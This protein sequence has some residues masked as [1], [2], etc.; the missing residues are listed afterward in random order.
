MD[1]ER[2]PDQ[3]RN[4]E[5]ARQIIADL[6]GVVRQLQIQVQTQ[7]SQ[8][9]ELKALVETLSEELANAKRSSRN[10]NHPPS[11][12]SPAQRAKRTRRKSSSRRQGAQPGHKKHQRSMLPEDQVDEI[13]RYFPDAHC[14]CGATLDISQTPDYRH[15]VFDLPE[16]KFHVS[17][18]QIYS[19]ICPRC[20]ATH[21]ARWPES[22][23]SGQMDA[24]LISTIVLLAG[25]FRLSVRQI[26]Q[27]L[28]QTWQLD[29]SVG[30]I[31]QAQG[32]ANDWM[33]PVYR[34]LG[35]QAR[36][37]EVAFADETR[38]FRGSEQRWL[39]TL[40]TGSVCFFMVHY[41]RGQQAA[42]E[43]LGDFKG[44][45]VTDHYSG[46]N[47]IEPS[48]RQLC[49]AHLIRHFVQI[50]ERTGQS[51]LIGQRLLLIAYVLFR[52]CRRYREDPEQ[53]WRLERRVN[54]LRRAF[55]TQ[56]QLGSAS[57]ASRTANQ[58]RHLL[59][60]EAMCWTFLSHPDIE[61]TN[62]SSE[63]A[64]RAYVL[65]R[66]FAYASQSHRGDQFRPMV[67]SLV[68]TALIRSMDAARLMREIC[69]Q[70]IRKGEVSVRI[71]PAELH[72]PARLLTVG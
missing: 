35:Q 1:L 62:N 36:R 65:W 38:H 70:G 49:W 39:W 5:E 22:V 54:R 11:G 33:G 4:L 40:V 56:L 31:S 47:Q 37:S 12:D 23:P 17:E 41:S 32:K 72:N 29:F 21:T 19:G 68:Q 7:A 8:I 61:L 57:P 43:L 10:S 48:R 14:R 27:Y 46:Y 45:L 30:A 44:Y 20:H 60:D 58:C 16:I 13:I 42:A 24:G 2:L 53:R 50:S 63:R 51:G 15:Q 34:D 69:T 6:V 55:V 26:Q 52:T 67:L 28:K 66:K 71:P 59:R 18:H 3:P 9:D 25:Q 64:L